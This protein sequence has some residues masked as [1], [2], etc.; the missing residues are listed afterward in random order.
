MTSG[1]APFGMKTRQSGREPPRSV[2]WKA[3]APGGRWSETIAS[4]R[5]WPKAPRDCL[6]ARM[7]VSVVTCPARSEMFCCAASSTARRSCRRFRLS[8]VFFVASPID[9]FMRCAMPSRRSETARLISACRP[10]SISAM[11][12]MRPV[13]ADWALSSAPTWPSSSTALSAASA[14]AR[15]P[16]ALMRQIVS[17][18][19]A[20]SS[21]TRMPK[22]EAASNT[23]T[24][25]PAMT[26]TMSFMPPV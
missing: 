13:I 18:Q 6:L 3:K 21:A 14:S 10:P 15:R 19:A 17:R 4:M 16:A 8:C 24:G 25:R 22:T 2:A 23:V 5:P 1:G 26:A 9:W 11:A 12:C 7:L 20:S